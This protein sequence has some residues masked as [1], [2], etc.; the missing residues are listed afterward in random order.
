MSSWL[1]INAPFTIVVLVKSGWYRFKVSLPA[2]MFNEHILTD[3]T[4]W[5]HKICCW[6]VGLEGWFALGMRLEARHLRRTDG[7]F[8]IHIMY[9]ILAKQFTMLCKIK[10]LCE[11]VKKKT[12]SKTWQESHRQSYSRLNIKDIITNPDNKAVD[13]DA[14]CI[15]EYRSRLG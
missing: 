14:E 5:R 1:N 3:G 2:H 6:P 15:Y 7:A 10:N 4:R 9:L 12:K 8:S 13:V 11:C